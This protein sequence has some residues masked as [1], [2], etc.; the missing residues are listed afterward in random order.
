MNTTIILPVSRAEYLQEIFAS[1]EF[2]ECDSK[3]TNLLVIVDG[4]PDLFVKVRDFV[5]ASKF[6]EKLCVQF[7]SPHTLRH[8]DTL[9]RRLRIS[10]IHNQLKQYIKNAEY[11]FGIEDDTIIPTNALK[12]LHNLFL[13]YPY[14]GLVQGITLGRHGIT[15]VG[16][17]RADDVYNPM[18][19]ESLSV[20]KESHGVREMDGG[21]LYCFMSRAEVYMGHTFA[22]FDNNNLGPDIN[23]TFDLRRQGFKNYTDLDLRCVHKDKKKSLSLNTTPAVQVIFTKQPNGQWRQQVVSVEI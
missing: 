20:T 7:S 16:A 11:I 2:L 13:E 19:V 3:Q 6:N 9:A 23:Y 22:P 12:R 15:H 8:Y 10:D 17:W 21:G 4:K 1:L 18:R 5:Q 14:A